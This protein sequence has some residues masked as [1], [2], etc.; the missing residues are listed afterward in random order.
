[1][2]QPLQLSAS[3]LGTPAPNFHW[4]KDDEELFI[5]SNLT[6][7]MTPDGSQ[8]TILH[9]EPQDGGTYTCTAVNTIGKCSWETTV[10]LKAKPSFDLPLSM[11]KPIA[12]QIDEMMTLKVPCIAVPEPQLG[13]YL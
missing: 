5:R 10:D 7:E 6:I 13:K 1:M 2:N 4:Y 8:L 12:F 9:A 3:A 11:Q